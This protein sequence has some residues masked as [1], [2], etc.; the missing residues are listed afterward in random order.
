MTDVTELLAVHKQAEASARR[1]PT[2]PTLQEHEAAVH[3]LEQ[4]RMSTGKQVN[5]EQTRVAKK[6]VDLGQWRGKREE[7]A[8]VTVG[9]GEEEAFNAK[10]WVSLPVG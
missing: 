6:E 5:E 2:V 7:V 3:A 1:P 9:E 4:Q 10:A 8:G